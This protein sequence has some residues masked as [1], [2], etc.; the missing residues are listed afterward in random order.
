MKMK[1]KLILKSKTSQ[2]NTVNIKITVPRATE[3][4]IEMIEET[5]TT[6]RAVTITTKKD[7]KIAT[8]NIS[9]ATT[10]I[11]ERITMIGIEITTEIEMKAI[12]MTGSMRIN[13]KINFM[14]RNTKKVK[15]DNHKILKLRNNRESKEGLNTKGIRKT[16][17]MIGNREIIKKI[18]IDREIM[19]ETM[20]I[21]ARNMIIETKTMIIRRE[22]MT[23]RR[24]ITT[25]IRRLKIKGMKRSPI[26]TE[27]TAIGLGEDTITIE[28]ITTIGIT[29]TTRITKTIE[30]TIKAQ[31]TQVKGAKAQTKGEKRSII[32]K[33]NKGRDLKIMR[34]FLKSPNKLIRIL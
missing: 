8:I 6:T 13:N 27:I 24:E 12:R 4:P 32:P 11:T 7:T 30:I 25:I 1:A 3:I 33:M 2:L 21:E 26:M 5:T 29:T 15:K 17:I 34:S 28:S 9:E 14:I 31:K 16:T 10:R 23:I 18:T 20:I 19:T 22:I